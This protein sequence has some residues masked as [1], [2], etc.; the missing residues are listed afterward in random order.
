MGMK[1]AFILRQGAKGRNVILEWRC[2]WSVLPFQS[3]HYQLQ[4]R[5]SEVPP[6]VNLNTFRSHLSD[7]LARQ[8]FQKARVGE[9]QNFHFH[10]FLNQNNT[11]LLLSWDST[12]IAYDQTGP[13]PHFSTWNFIPT[14]VSCALQRLALSSTGIPKH[15]TWPSSVCTLPLGHFIPNTTECLRLT[16]HCMGCFS[17]NHVFLWRCLGGL[18]T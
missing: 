17:F 4:L 6:H 15:W 14:L 5:P 11:I 8:D 12:F 16:W 10:H 1:F 3:S 13:Q 18:V 2:R 9:N 7:A